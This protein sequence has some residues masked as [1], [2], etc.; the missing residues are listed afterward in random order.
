MS[1]EWDFLS[2]CR[3]ETEYRTIDATYNDEVRF[4]VLAS[5]IVL[6][7]VNARLS[8]TDMR[9]LGELLL[10]GAAALD[11]SAPTPPAGYTQPLPLHRTEANYGGVVCSTCDGGGCLDCTDPA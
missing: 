5:G 4:T 1:G 10:E 7:A 11:D 9:T 8:S 2:S 6:S 3:V